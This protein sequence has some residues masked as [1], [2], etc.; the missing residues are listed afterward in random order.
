M[1]YCFTFIFSHNNTKINKFNQDLT[2]LLMTAPFYGPKA[3]YF[4]CCLLSSVHMHRR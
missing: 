3:K 1:L 2:E 4:F